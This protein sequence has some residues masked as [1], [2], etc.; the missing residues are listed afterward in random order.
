M[1][2][3]V[4]VS[5][6]VLAQLQA[7]AEVRGVTV[8]QLAAETIAQAATADDVLGVVR[9]TVTEHGEILDRLTGT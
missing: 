2:L 4:E 9:D 8:D 7:S 6:E 3:R 1:I 5:A